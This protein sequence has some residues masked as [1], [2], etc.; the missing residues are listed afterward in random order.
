MSEWTGAEQK[1]TA[2]LDERVHV[3]RERQNHAWLVHVEGGLV[4]AGALRVGVVNRLVSDALHALGT[5]QLA[6][7]SEWR[8]SN[9]FISC[10]VLCEGVL[11]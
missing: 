8:C 10:P 6:A 9:S 11:L 5:K 3:L 7:T 1:S 2:R 4:C